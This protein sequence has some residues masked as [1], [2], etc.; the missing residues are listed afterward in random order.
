[1]H[2]TIQWAVVKQKKKMTSQCSWLKLPFSLPTHFQ[3]VIFTPQSVITA[4]LHYSLS[5]YLPG[6]QSILTCHSTYNHFPTLVTSYI[7]SL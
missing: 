2:I 6:L 1:M 7:F 3:K 4:C 5:T